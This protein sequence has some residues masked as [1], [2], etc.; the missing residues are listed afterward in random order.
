MSCGRE[1]SR[2]PSHLASAPSWLPVRR[3]TEPK[4]GPRDPSRETGGPP[5]AS[6]VRTNRRHRGTPRMTQTHGRLRCSE[7]PLDPGCDRD[8]TGAPAN[9]SRCQ[10]T[11]AAGCSHPRRCTRDRRRTGRARTRWHPAGRRGGRR[12][13]RP[14]RTWA[15][16]PQPRWSFLRTRPPCQRMAAIPARAI[17][18]APEEGLA[19]YPR[20]VSSRPA[21]NEQVA[22]STELSCRLQSRTPAVTGCARRRWFEGFRSCATTS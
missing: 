4:R 17:A 22:A 20:L 16:H 14:P 13:A 12:S 18:E 9:H 8:V 10:A 15:D 7:P 6:L 11:Q 3:G 2:Q 19:S 1:S 5:P 21:S